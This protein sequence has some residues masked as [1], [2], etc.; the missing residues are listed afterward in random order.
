M[1]LTDV[2]DAEQQRAGG[3][4]A[5]AVASRCAMTPVRGE[6]TTKA[7]PASTEAPV[8]AAVYC[9]KL[10]SAARP[11]LCLFFRGAS[12]VQPLRRRGPRLGQSLGALTITRRQGED[13]LRLRSGALQLR[14]IG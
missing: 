7:L 6:R 1:Q 10:V 4:F 5:P 8:R 9:T 3:T 14:H 11:C 12:L 2:D 13:R